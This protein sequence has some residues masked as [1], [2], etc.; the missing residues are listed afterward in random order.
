MMAA[1]VAFGVFYVAFPLAVLGLALARLLWPQQRRAT[2]IPPPPEGGVDQEVARL[3]APLPQAIRVPEDKRTAFLRLTTCI[4]DARRYCSAD[5]YT[6][7]Y[8]NA[9][10]LINV[11]LGE[12]ERSF[13]QAPL[14]TGLVADLLD[15]SLAALRDRDRVGLYVALTDL[16]ALA[17]RREHYQRW[18]PEEPVSRSPH[19][20]ALLDE[21]AA[22][23]TLLV[24]SDAQGEFQRRLAR[25]RQRERWRAAASDLLL[26][27]SYLAQRMN[28]PRLT[29][30]LA[31][32]QEAIALQRE[33]YSIAALGWSVAQ[34]LRQRDYAI[35]LDLLVG[36][37]ASLVA[38]NGTSAPSPAVRLT[39]GVLARNGENNNG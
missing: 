3:L 1:W 31:P 25:W 18:T 11:A 5:P 10:R 12:D 20:Q 9:L 14:V 28:Q 27:F 8:L 21:L 15:Q 30:A 23:A 29:P 36:D 2:P 34:G 22:L 32:A 33:R 26:P 6:C 19:D 17:L 37:L 4:N 16:F 7:Y 39:P 38:G 35:V 13:L 24:H